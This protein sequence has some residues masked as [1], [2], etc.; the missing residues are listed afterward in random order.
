MRKKNLLAIITLFILI[1]CEKNEKEEIITSINDY[2]TSIAID[3]NN[4]R[5]VGTEKGL[6]KSTDNGYMHQNISISGKVLSLTYDESS[7]TL[8]VG[9]EAGLSEVSL[10]SGNASGTVV[11]TENLSNSSILISY[12]D[13][14]SRLW[15]GTGKGIS[16]N[17]D[18]I[19]KN[20]SFRVNVLGTMFP[21]NAENL[22]VNSIAAWDND[23]YFA[24]SGGHLYRAFGLVDSID[25]FS[26]AS[27]WLSPYNG[28]NVTDTMFMVF[29]D[30]KG[31]QWMGGK[32]GIQVHTGHKPKEE[33]SFTYYNN[34]LADNRIHAIAEAPDGKIWVGTEK[35]LSVFNGSSWSTVTENLPDM[36]V[37]S[38]AFDQDG[39]AWVGTRKGLTNIR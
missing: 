14:T 31:N 34:E 11:P 19:W 26:G 39:S 25:A 2:V 9:T 13:T 22:A 20:D 21:M 33:S 8:W 24:T 5:W 36:Y 38:I 37:T 7:N 12:K 27:Q 23:Y 32:N 16:L 18:G 35:G 1:A 17:K 30:S 10:T 15:F 28:Q 3:E 4:T 6:Y 29:V